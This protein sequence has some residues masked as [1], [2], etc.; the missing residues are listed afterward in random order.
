MKPQETRFFRGGAGT[1]PPRTREQVASEQMNKFRKVL[2]TKEQSQK[3]RQKWES[4]GPSGAG[5]SKD[6]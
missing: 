4:Q 2:K 1:I 3:K 5:R 6:S